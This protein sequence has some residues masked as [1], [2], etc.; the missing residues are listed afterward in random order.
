MALA[1]H[2]LDKNSKNKAAPQRLIYWLR[3]QWPEEVGCSGPD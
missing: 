2:K 1:P 3:Q